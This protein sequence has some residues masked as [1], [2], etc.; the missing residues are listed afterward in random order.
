MDPVSKRHNER[1]SEVDDD[2]GGGQLYWMN[3]KKGAVLLKSKRKKISSME[4]GRREGPVMLI[5][6]HTVP[7]DESYCTV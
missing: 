6:N 5:Q 4:D 3:E 2:L 7:Y 1:T